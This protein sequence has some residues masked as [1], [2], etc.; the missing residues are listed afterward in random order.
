[1]EKVE[2]AP[3]EPRGTILELLSDGEL[4]TQEIGQ[5]LSRRGKRL[6]GSAVWYHLQELERGELIRSQRRQGR[7]GRGFSTY[8]NLTERGRN[9]LFGYLVL[10]YQDDL[11]GGLL[12][13]SLHDE[14]SIKQRVALSSPAKS[15]L[16]MSSLEKGGYRVLARLWK[17]QKLTHKQVK[18][19]LKEIEAA[20]SSHPEHEEYLTK[21]E[22][23][24]RLALKQRK[25]IALG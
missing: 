11:P 3:A 10:K 20:K 7:S 8:W 2:V 4:T 17:E 15:H 24:A 23:L 6:A 19:L 13:L 22:E 18:T 1:M 14:N 16:V 9:A 12:H 25:H 5:A 21:I